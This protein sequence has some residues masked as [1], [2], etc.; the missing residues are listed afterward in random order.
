V[1][2]RKDIINLRNKK[3]VLY[4]FLPFSEKLQC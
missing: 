1:E 2:M 3:I 4:V